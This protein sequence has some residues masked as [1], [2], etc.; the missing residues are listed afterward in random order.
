MS[1]Q[2]LKPSLLSEKFTDLNTPPISVDTDI[3]G[4]KA[5]ALYKF[6]KIISPGIG[7]NV[8]NTLLDMEK[9]SNKLIADIDPQKRDA[10]IKDLEDVTVEIH[11]AVKSKGKEILSVPISISPAEVLKNAA[12]GKRNSRYDEKMKDEINKIVMSFIKK[13]VE[14]KVKNIAEIFLSVL[15]LKPGTDSMFGKLLNRGLIDEEGHLAEGTTIDDL[16]TGKYTEQFNKVIPEE[17]ISETLLIRDTINT[18]YDWDD[19]NYQDLANE[20]LGKKGILEITLGVV[21]KSSDP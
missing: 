6:T 3:L 7:T 4:D 21:E 13:G 9:R 8:L 2:A 19:E 5:L 10:L 1:K 12:S 16:I 18:F 20:A 14:N 17:L 11:Y 15:H